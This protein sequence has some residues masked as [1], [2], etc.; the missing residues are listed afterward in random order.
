MGYRMTEA[1]YQELLNR[2]KIPR[3]AIIQGPA[4]P[5]L[6]QSRAYRSK[7]EADYADHL[8]LLVYAK[9]IDCWY[10]EKWKFRLGRGVWYL[11][12]FIV[13]RGWIVEAHEVK[14]PY[15]R[16]T[17]RVKFRTAA[18]EF[19]QIH[20]FWVTRDKSG[21]WIAKEEVPCSG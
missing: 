4:I 11:P 18:S 6:V 15:A 17:G 5:A 8:N 16:D 7:L 14:G 21:H 13:F 1:E 20:W 10:Y 12:D 3:P 19:P 9:E 2:G